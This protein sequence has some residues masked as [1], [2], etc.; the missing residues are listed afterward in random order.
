VPADASDHRTGDDFERAYMAM[1]GPKYAW[2]NFRLRMAA[3]AVYDPTGEP[4]VA[5][6]FNAFRVDD[7][8]LAT[9]LGD[10]VDPTLASFARTF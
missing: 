4:A 7:E 5:H 8:S 10:A 6:L 3:A 9:L 1:P 2:F